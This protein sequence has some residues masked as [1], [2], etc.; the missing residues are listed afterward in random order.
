M[1]LQEA[2]DN[3]TQIL[4]EER[5][6]P[7]VEYLPSDEITKYDN[8]VSQTAAAVLSAMSHGLAQQELFQLRIQRPRQIVEDTRRYRFKSANYDLLSALMSRLPSQSRPGFTT[9]LLS[10]M[11]VPPACG[12]T[13]SVGLHTWDG[14]TSELPLIA[15]FVVR[16]SGKE[17]FIGSLAEL[18]PLPGH[19]LLLRQ[20]EEIISLEFTLFTDAEY[21]LLS[22]S[23]DK[24][25]RT[26]KESLKA[27]V[28]MPNDYWNFPEL[29]MVRMG[30]TLREMIEATDGL[31]EQCRKSQF[32]Y[33]KGLLLEGANL[34]VNQD[35]E[36]VRHY[37][38]EFDF[39]SALI[40]SLDV[41]EQLYLN[42]G[43][44]FDYKSC[45][46]HLR[47]FLENLHKV[48][49]RDIAAKTGETTPENWGGSLSYL[50]T[51]G[52]LTQPE[53]KLASSLYTLMSDEAV[54]PL[55][56]E[57]EYARLARNMV[58]EYGLLFLRRL[59]KLGQRTTSQRPI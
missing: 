18:S 25:A 48:A 39:S 16:N 21:Q 3:A 58:I 8:R 40:E 38:K 11:G 17:G 31:K 49:V 36:V 53:E 57:R 2:L 56:A 45:I 24:L 4:D 9:G 5:K 10:R 50:R 28:K 37:L 12:R 6:F 33:L 35:K 27:T 26:A 42:P 52:V 34:E 41:A 15:Q 46:G 20:L 47:S 29:G 7:T 22:A 59:D 23:V 14:F 13:R 51:G 1:E 30:G 43:T 55:I 54:H 44:S 32:L 19:V